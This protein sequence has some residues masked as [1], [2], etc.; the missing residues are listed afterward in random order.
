MNADGSTMD[1]RPDDSH[2]LDE[3]LGAY[4]LDA[5]DD[6][7]RRRVEEYLE[8]NPRAAA[9]VRDH[10]EVATMLAYTG[11]DAPEGLWGRIAGELDAPAPPPPAALGEVLSLDGPRRRRRLATIAPLVG[12]AAAAILVTV[13]TLAVVDRSDAPADPMAAAVEAARAD[14]DTLVAELASEASDAT[15]EGLLDQDGHGYLDAS[16][17]PTLGDDQTYQL[18]GVLDGNGDVVS[19]GILGPRPELETFTVEGEVAALA[20]TI[21]D[22]PGV[23]A[24][25]NPDGAFVGELG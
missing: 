8:I 21:E 24:D 2:D 25:G 20:V 19:L 1:S 5:V 6:D 4:A 10:R 13:V 18:W 12:A 9:E 3:L 23:V 16:R 14:R 17:L 11:A 15:A 7:E 22:A